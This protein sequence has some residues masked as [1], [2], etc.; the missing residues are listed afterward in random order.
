MMSASVN[1]KA[2]TVSSELAAVAQ[3]RQHNEES[4]L[5][6]NSKK[7]HFNYANNVS[8]YISLKILGSYITTFTLPQF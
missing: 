8:A 2:A 1:Q 7:Y 3:K 6:S 4:F 5:H